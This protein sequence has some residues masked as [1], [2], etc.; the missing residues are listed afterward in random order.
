MSKS[1]IVL[2]LLSTASAPLLAQTASSAP[3]VTAAAPAKPQMIKK[4]V[5]VRD[6]EDSYSRLGGRK[7]CRTIEVPAPASSGTAPQQA[8]G[9]A[10][11]AS[12]N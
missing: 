4:Q 6:D 10:Q 12:A 9:P 1:L 5:C 7:I 2:A 3:T 11:P 8:P